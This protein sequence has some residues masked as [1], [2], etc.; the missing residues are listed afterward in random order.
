MEAEEAIVRDKE[1][2]EAIWK[3]LEEVTTL[4]EQQ[5]ICIYI[6]EHWT[7]LWMHMSSSIIN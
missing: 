4:L 1:A 3:E 6:E 5:S 7:H 2:R